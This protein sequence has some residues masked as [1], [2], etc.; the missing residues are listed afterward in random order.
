MFRRLPSRRSLL[1]ALGAIA[2]IAVGTAA[3][4]Y[5]TTS[6]SGSGSADAGTTSGLTVNQSTTLTAMFPGDS[7][8]TISGTF[9]NPNAGPAY[10]GTVTASIT[11]VTKAAGAVA[12]TC[13]ASDFTLATPVMTVGAEI[14][15]GTAQGAWT[16]ATL[17]FNDKTTTNQDA[18]KSA[19][20][21]LGYA[22][23]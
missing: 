12:G 14:P 13:D 5:W 16:G 23:G 22:I 1:T 18:C 7:A 4:A 10:V 9:D 3:F 15:A 6:G 2:V 19:T 21:N 20:V 17:K 8:Q 11:S